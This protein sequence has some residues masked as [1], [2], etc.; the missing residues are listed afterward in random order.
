MASV[1]DLQGLVERLKSGTMLADEVR[2][3]LHHK[4]PLVRANAIEALAGLARDDDRLVDELIA[5]ASDP[6]NNVRLM[7]TISVAHVAVGCLLRVATA[8]ALEAAK[9][10][11]SEWPEPDRTDLIWY[12]G[13]EGLSGK[14]DAALFESKTGREVTS[15]F[16][17]PFPLLPKS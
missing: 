4:S 11:L 6:Q 7:G 16:S 1:K 3:L 14:G 2:G 8:K 9:A 15:S 17:L 10:L 12:L 13:S 5:A